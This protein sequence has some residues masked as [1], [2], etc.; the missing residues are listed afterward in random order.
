MINDIYKK[1]VYRAC[2]FLVFR[3]MKD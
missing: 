1:S 3:N 2:G